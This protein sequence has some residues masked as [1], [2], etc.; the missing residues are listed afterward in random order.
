MPLDIS[1]KDGVEYNIEDVRNT[2]K[3]IKAYLMCIYDL[4]LS[5]LDQLVKSS[6]ETSTSEDSTV[7]IIQEYIREI[8]NIINSSQYNGKQLLANKNEIKKLVYRLAGSSDNSNNRNDFKLEVP[9]IDISNLH[10]IHL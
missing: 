1:T 4:L 6:L 3:Q 8:Q 5:C 9:I 7:A 2:I 10:L